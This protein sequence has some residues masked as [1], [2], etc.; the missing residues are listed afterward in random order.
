V[1][2]KSKMANN[3]FTM[4]NASMDDAAMENVEKSTH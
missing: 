2:P 1:I 4:M 3:A